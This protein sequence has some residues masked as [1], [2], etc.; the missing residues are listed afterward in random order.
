MTFKR[1]LEEN[2]IIHEGKKLSFGY[3]TGSCAAAASKAAAIMMFSGSTIDEVG[4]D[5]PG[6]VLLHLEVLDIQMDRAKTSCAIRKDGGDDPDA[7]TGMLVYSTVERC[8]EPG[9]HIQGGPG[10]GRVTKPGL[11]QNVGE[12][13][14]NH[15]P[16][17]MITKSLEE[18]CASCGYTEGLTVTISIPGGE[19]TA[20][21]TFN[22]RLGIEG[23]LSILGTSGIVVPM[24]E[25]ALIKTIETEMSMLASAGKKD[26]LISPGNYGKHFAMHELHREPDLICSNFVGKTI[27]IAV[28]MGVR[29]ILFVAHIGKFIKVAGGIMN[30]HSRESDCRLEVLSAC[31]LT[32]G[33][34]IQTALALLDA[35][36]TEDGVEILKQSDCLEDTMA[37]VKDRILYYLDHRANGA[38]QFDVILFSNKEGRL[39]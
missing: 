10:V 16:R 28:N 3:T 32:A 11:D 38:I 25:E 15:V 18:I 33:A 31:A 26:L 14:I 6:G 13:A 30:T 35:A 1:N 7:T 20:E 2:Y 12:Y 19:I 39:I 8:R 17:E 5:T 34:D 29:N 22:P 24:S 27:D 36:T 37:I 23:G 9:I 4:L 21:H